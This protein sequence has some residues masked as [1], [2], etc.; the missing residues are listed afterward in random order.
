MSGKNLFTNLRVP[1]I[2][3]VRRDR[4]LP[5]R[6]V[7]RV[8]EFGNAVVRLR[9]Q[10]DMVDVVVHEVAP[11]RHDVIRRAQLLG[12]SPFDETRYAVADEMTVVVVAVFRQPAFAEHEVA[13]FGEV[14]Y[15]VEQR[16]V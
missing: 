10:V 11:R 3:L 16:A 6:T 2:E 14:A 13:T 7:E 4:Q 15:R 12:Q 1:S 9:V 8:H 5:A